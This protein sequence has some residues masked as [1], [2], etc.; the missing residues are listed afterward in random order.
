MSGQNLNRINQGILALVMAYSV[1]A[2]LEDVLV[3]G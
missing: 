1:E 2:V 3:A